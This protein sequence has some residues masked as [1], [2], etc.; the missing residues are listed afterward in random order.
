MLD[1][2]HVDVTA[3]S[4]RRDSWLHYGCRAHYQ[5]SLAGRIIAKKFV[6]VE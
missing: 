3:V 4:R 1:I 2:I 6:I 5:R